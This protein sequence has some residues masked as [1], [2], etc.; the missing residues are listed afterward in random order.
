MRVSDRVCV[1][2]TCWL[3][4]KAKTVCASPSASASASLLASFRLH[5]LQ[6]LQF[7]QLA[8]NS[9]ANLWEI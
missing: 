8:V 5:S 2:V 6:S 7:T 4:A 3:L 1:C 9:L